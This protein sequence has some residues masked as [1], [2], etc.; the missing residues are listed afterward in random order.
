MRSRAT[1]ESGKADGHVSEEVGAPPV[2]RGRP[3]T[4]VR[5]GSLALAAVVVLCGITLVLGF[6][7]KDRCT[8]PEFE[9]DG[10]STPNYDLRS[11]RDVCYSDIQHLWI[12]RDI[13]KHVFPYVNGG[14][15]EYDQPAGGVVEYP[16]LTGMLMWVSAL[17]ADT[18]ADF[19]LLS[20][21]VLSPFGMAI[22]WMLGRMSR[23]RSLLWAIGPPLVLYAF[24]NWDLPVVLCAVAAVYVVHLGW[25]R[26]GADRPLMTRA[27]AAAVLLALGFALKVYPAIFVLPLMLYVL[28][29]GAGGRALTGKALDWVGALRVALVA[30]GTV[31]AVNLP[32]AVAGFEGWR[33]SFTFQMLREADITTN[34]IWYW[35]LRPHTDPDDT[36]MHELIGVLSPTLVLAS[37]VLAC[38][39]GWLRYQKE[40]TYPWIAVSAA[41]LCGFLL[42]HKVHSPQYTLWLVPMFVLLRIRWG[43]IAAYLVADIAMGI[44]I[45]RWFYEI[46]YGNAGGIFDGFAAQALMIGVW[47]R[48]GLL[49]GL[50]YVF[51]VS[52]STLPEDDPAP[53]GAGRSSPSFLPAR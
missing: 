39:I 31:V 43:W 52:R 10:R 6:L 33:A 14:L 34:S 49:V 4:A 27:T 9:E 1:E 36:G 30:L 51:L 15:N 38:G 8:G 53:L 20:A 50:F 2:V 28:T 46:F 5:L 22:A 29:G 3:G 23:W 18:D 48:A 12:G 47:G 7:N 16:V 40:G 45:F 35:G 37:F 41:M 26:R 24:H 13:D 11:K 42:L 19:L 17:F 21:L 32:F 44:G 25:G